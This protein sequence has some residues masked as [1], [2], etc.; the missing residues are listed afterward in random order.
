MHE[1]FHLHEFSLKSFVENGKINNYKVVN[2]KYGICETFLPKIFDP[3]LKRI[4]KQT[5]TGMEI[6]L[7]LQKIK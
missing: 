5:N 2:H 4:M 7:L 3:I 1:P 6:Y